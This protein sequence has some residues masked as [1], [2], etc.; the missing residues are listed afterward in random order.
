MKKI[1]LFGA[2]GNVG[3]YMTKYMS[4][5]FAGT[6]YEVIASGRR[7]TKV[8]DQFGIDY[9]SVDITDKKAFKK[10]S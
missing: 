8:F 3:S 10:T 6:E 2:T 5:Y 7:E 9:C 4:E 1:I